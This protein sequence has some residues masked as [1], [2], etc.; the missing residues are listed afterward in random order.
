MTTPGSWEWESLVWVRKSKEWL[1]RSAD[2]LRLW[3]AISWLVLL[4]VLLGTA[5]ACDDA[6]IS[7]RTIDNFVHGEGLVFNPGERVQAFTHPLWLLLHVPFY[8]LT[9]NIYYVTIILSL[10]LSLG[11]AAVLA[12]VVDSRLAWGVVPIFIVLSKSLTDYASSGLENP[13]TH[14]LLACFAW[15]Y[16]ERRAHPRQFLHLGL[17]FALLFVNRMDAILLLAPALLWRTWEGLSWR[18]IRQLA[19]GMTP[20][21]AWEAFSIVYYGFPFPNTAYAKL[22]TGIPQQELQLAGIFYFLDSFRRDIFT[23]LLIVVGGLTGLSQRRTW[24]L[25]IGIGLYLLYILRI[26]GDFMSGRFLSAPATL[27]VLVLLY[28]VRDRELG[29]RRVNRALFV[30]VM[31]NVLLWGL[32]HD[33]PARQLP[34]ISRQGIADERSFYEPGTGLVHALEGRRLPDFRWVEDGKRIATSPE[35]VHLAYNIGFS[36]F[37][38]GPGHH[39]IDRYALSDPLLARLPRLHHPDQR[40]GHY[41]RVLPEGYVRSVRQDTNALVDPVLRTLYADLRLITR[42][43]VWSRARWA[44]IWRQNFEP[45][46]DLSWYAAP[47]VH[48]IVLGDDRHQSWTLYPNKGLRILRKDREGTHLRFCNGGKCDYVIAHHWRGGRVHADFGGPHL[49]R[50]DT[51]AFETHFASYVDSLTVYPVGDCGGLWISDVEPFEENY[52]D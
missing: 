23:L 31:V 24:P 36:G 28:A 11:T 4:W 19:L 51:A 9:G 8:A 12:R 33:H 14:F 18:T 43:P 13:L 22:G 15:V 44:A 2:W 40:P 30:I 16:L 3:P 10:L 39:L 45:R 20:I 1:H 37:Y 29:Q 46:P 5:W 25:A 48:R 38:A 17:L 21:L 42:G 6:Y 35:R 32:H 34:L 47:A 50:A 52:D 7:F 41:E 26:G 27:A 49:N